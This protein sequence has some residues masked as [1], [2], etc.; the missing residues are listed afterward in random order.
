MTPQPR[1]P[2]V[3]LVSLVGAGPGDP[4]LITLRGADCLR[5]AE[6][7]IY[8]HLA[9]PALLDYCPPDAER[10]NAGKAAG[11]HTLSQDAIER[12][13]LAR[14]RAGRRVVRLKGGDPYL[15]GRG[16]EEGEALARAG[17]PFEVVPG[18]TSAVAVP[19]YAGIPLTHREHASSVAIVTGHEDP[20]KP[21]SQL[22]WPALAKSADTI[23]CLMGVRQLPEMVKQLLAHG[24]ASST[25]CAVIEWGTLPRQRTI[26]G[27]LA[28]IAPLAKRAKL[29]PPAICI[30]GD[31]VRLRARLNWFEARPLFGRRVLVTRPLAEA[32]GL[33]ESLARAGADV[34]TLPAIEAL[35]LED[36]SLLDQAIRHMDSYHWL[37]F[38]SAVGVQ[39]FFRRLA[40]LQRDVRA[41]A[42]MRLGVVGPKT[43]QALRKLGLR[44]DFVPT[45]TRQEGMITELLPETVHGQRILI[46]RA[47]QARDVLP[48]GLKRMGAA[49]EV[50]PVYRTVP[51]PS[52][53][54]RLAALEPAVGP[55]IVT[56]TSSSCVRHLWEALPPAQRKAF[57]ARVITAS[58]GPVTSATLREHKLPVHVEAP[59]ATIEALTQAIVAHVRAP[60][61]APARRGAA[62]RASR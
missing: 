3:G 29:E 45:D 14:A 37:F 35:P 61:R 6:V 23:V 27:T 62:A 41:L 21:S 19:A 15:F 39:Y 58:I 34:V 13:M 42:G 59:T 47:E 60:K 40:H 50:V 48:E 9:H 36:Y 1:T 5:E 24:R 28:T 26:T 56:F 33:A 44:V 32:R 43:A 20:S 17:I 16:G 54:E 12:L 18:V 4:Q 7:V 30:V 57:F 8:D 52:F 22:H 31:V 38:T 11:K 53:A 25:P 46:A 49:V 10:V 55:T 51:P 2:T